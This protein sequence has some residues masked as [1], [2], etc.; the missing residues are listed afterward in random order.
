M[1]IID[2][3]LEGGHEPES[4]EG[5][6]DL[7]KGEGNVGNVILTQYSDGGFKIGSL[8][9]QREDLIELIDFVKAID[10]AL[11]HGK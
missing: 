1:D 3:L 7:S 4:K 2:H 9:L 10:T 11:D 5:Q 8:T 6:F